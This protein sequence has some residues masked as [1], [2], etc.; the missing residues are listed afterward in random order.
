[1]D[2]LSE[3]EIL[4]NLIKKYDFLAN[5]LP[6]N[7]GVSSVLVYFFLRNDSTILFTTYIT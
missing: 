6:L 4:E 1:M 5:I 7:I 2:S 3:R